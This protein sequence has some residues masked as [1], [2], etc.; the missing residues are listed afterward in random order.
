MQALE[1]TP[2]GFNSPATRV[3]PSHISSVSELREASFVDLQHL[4]SYRHTALVAAL[5]SIDAES[6]CQA[7]FGKTADLGG[8]GMAIV[9][10][11]VVHS[12]VVR[13]LD[14]EG[15]AVAQLVCPIDVANVAAE[16]LRDAGVRQVMDIPS[17]PREIDEWR[18]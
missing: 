9:R 2:P 17:I 7:L 10:S 18:R 12:S 13:L 16:R 3:S 4:T 15:L 11:V 5:P 14:L 8:S 6:L 1:T